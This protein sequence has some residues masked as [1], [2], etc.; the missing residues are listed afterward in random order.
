M[1]CSIV[2]TSSDRIQIS[3]LLTNVGACEAG[4]FISKSFGQLIMFLSLPRKP[5]SE[6]YKLTRAAHKHRE[7]VRFVCYVT[8]LAIHSEY[9]VM[10]HR[11]QLTNHSPIRPQICIFNDDE[12]PKNIDFHPAQA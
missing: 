7:A 2:E 10:C 8:I 12:S 6:R 5:R 1:Q 4:P 11:P 3:C 9:Q